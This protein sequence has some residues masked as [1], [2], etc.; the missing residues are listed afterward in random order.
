MK[1]IDVLL[2]GRECLPRIVNQV[3]DGLTVVEV[4]SVDDNLHA[5]V[6]AKIDVI[7]ETVDALHVEEKWM[8]QINNVLNDFMS[9]FKCA[10]FDDRYEPTTIEEQEYEFQDEGDHASVS[11][12]QNN[13]N[14]LT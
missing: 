11:R 14:K 13:K 9:I 10:N 3:N 12:L 2:N 7:S 8:N 1:Y 5:K 4:D 6:E